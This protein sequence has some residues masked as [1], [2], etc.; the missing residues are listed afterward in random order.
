MTNDNTI[1]HQK[2]PGTFPLIGQTH[3]EHTRVNNKKWKRIRREE[4]P[5]A[6]NR[7]HVDCRTS[8]TSDS[9]IIPIILFQVSCLPLLTNT[10]HLLYKHAIELHTP[11]QTHTLPVRPNQVME[12]TEPRSHLLS[13]KTKMQKRTADLWPR[14]DRR[15]NTAPASIRIL[16]TQDSKLMAWAP[17]TWAYISPRCGDYSPWP[18][19]AIWPC[20]HSRSCFAVK[21]YDFTKKILVIF[22]AM[23]N[24][25]II[26]FWEG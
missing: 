20:V 12:E 17:R 6:P 22:I 5:S 21:T 16:L 3:T 14:Q 4:L 15:L 8:L 25:G 23:S 26:R 13:P 1:R 9:V 24:P 7:G 10:S 19:R 11:P 2:P 18:E